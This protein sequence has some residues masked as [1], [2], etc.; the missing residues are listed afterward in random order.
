MSTIAI[1]KKKMIMMMTTM[2]TP[3]TV[4]KTVKQEENN[5]KE[6]GAVRGEEDGD[7]IPFIPKTAA[8]P[9]S[10]AR[11]TATYAIIDLI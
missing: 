5:E 11:G 10:V 3:T 6:A 8:T 4:T 7:N 1:I 9:S 2:T